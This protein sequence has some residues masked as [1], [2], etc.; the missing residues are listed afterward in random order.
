MCNKVCKID[1]LSGCEQCDVKP[2]PCSQGVQDF[3]KNPGKRHEKGFLNCRCDS[4]PMHSLCGRVG[5]GR[6][7]KEQNKTHFFQ[8]ILLRFLNHLRFG[9][10]LLSY[11][12]ISVEFQHYFIAFQAANLFYLY[13]FWTK[14]MATIN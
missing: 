1:P 5:I 8:R 13:I 3:W 12:S 7:G 4:W 11:E 2:H 9:R 14:T 6:Q 10:N